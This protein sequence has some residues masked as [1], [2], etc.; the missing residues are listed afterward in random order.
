MKT[1]GFWEIPETDEEVV[2]QIKKQYSDELLI[3]NL[4]GIFQV[5]RKRGDDVSAAYEYTL[6]AHINAGKQNRA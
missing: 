3:K 4:T 5:R 6:K 2:R 1:I